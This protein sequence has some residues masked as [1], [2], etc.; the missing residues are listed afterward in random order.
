VS[1]GLITRHQDRVA[2]NVDEGDRG[3]SPVCLA[4]AQW[5]YPLDHYLIDD[6]ANCMDFEVG[7]RSFGPRPNASPI[8]R[9]GG[10]NTRAQLG[11][12]TSKCINPFQSREPL[13]KQGA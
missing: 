13:L 1:A 2:N 11:N 9:S 10:V 7:F 5:L 6:T 8:P 4:C 3:E 12:R